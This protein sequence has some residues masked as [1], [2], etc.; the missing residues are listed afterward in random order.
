MAGSARVKHLGGPTTRLGIAALDRPGA[1]TGRLAVSLGLGLTL[2]VT[3]AATAS[4]IVAEID[5]SVPKKAPALFLVDIPREQAQRITALTGALLPGAELRLVPSL[6]GP[7]TAVNG[8]RVT[9]L[10]AIPEGAWILRG[11]RGLTFAAALPPANRVVLANGGPRIIAVR[12]WSAS[13]WMRRPRLALRLA[14]R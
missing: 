4:S 5:T 14:I 8:T 13:T 1:A 2:L 10:K 6:R 3:L 12:R 7:V 9:E 11:D